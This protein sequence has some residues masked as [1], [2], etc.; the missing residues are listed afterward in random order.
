MRVG[1]GIRE[2]SKKLFLKLVCNCHLTIQ[3][4][5]L[6]IHFS[7]K[8]PPTTFTNVLCKSHL[9][10]VKVLCWF[11]RLIAFL[12]RWRMSQLTLSNLPPHRASLP[13]GLIIRIGPLP[14]K[15][16]VAAQPIL[17]LNLTFV[18]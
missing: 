12:S 8:P 2:M 9:L 18:M 6:I 10:T 3:R 14:T 16:V 17:G 7:S 11:L 5:F 15:V 1:K 13:S 4:H